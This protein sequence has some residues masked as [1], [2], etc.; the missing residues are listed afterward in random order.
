MRYNTKTISSFSF[1]NA[2][3]YLQWNDDPSLLEANEIEKK[4]ITIRKT[5]RRVKL[6]AHKQRSKYIVKALNVVEVG[7]H[8]VWRFFL[9]QNT[10]NVPSNIAILNHYRVCEYGGDDCV[11]LLSTVDRTLYRYRQSLTC[12]VAQKLSSLSKKCDLPNIN[13]GDVLKVCKKWHRRS[14]SWKLHVPSLGR[15]T[16]AW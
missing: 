16:R 12:N 5:R 13:F 4:L 11:R 9:N 8:F 7:N 2:F 15:A 6:N 14:K 10:L 3:F 1:Q